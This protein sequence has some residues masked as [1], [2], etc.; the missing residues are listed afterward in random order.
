MTGQTADTSFLC[1]PALFPT[2]A[3]FDFGA[4]LQDGPAVAYTDIV[5][6]ARI[7]M[8][9]DAVREIFNVIPPGIVCVLYLSL[10]DCS[11]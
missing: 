7:A 5:A 8:T 9:A 6:T 4:I 1:E 10:T 2:A 3:V 11:G